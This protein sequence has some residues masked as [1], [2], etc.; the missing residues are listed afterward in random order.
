MGKLKE[1]KWRA[2]SDL[3]TLLSAI[4]IRADKTRY[5][6][7]MKI[8]KQRKSDLSSVCDGDMDD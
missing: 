4:R 8:A 5:S 3:E 1:A 6:N 7:A 2:E